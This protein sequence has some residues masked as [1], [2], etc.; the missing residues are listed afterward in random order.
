VTGIVDVFEFFLTQSERPTFLWQHSA[1]PDRKTF[2]K[3]DS[4]FWE[5][6][7]TAKAVLFVRSTGRGRKLLV[8]HVTDCV[9][10]FQ[11]YHTKLNF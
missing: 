7:K 5:E 9:E 4:A 8:W 10:C 2:Y 6:S 11:D 1:T 3:Q